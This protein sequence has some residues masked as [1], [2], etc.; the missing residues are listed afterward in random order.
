MDVPLLGLPAS[1]WMCFWHPSACVGRTSTSPTWSS[2]ARPDNRD[3]LPGEMQACQP[4]LDSQLEMISPKVVVTLGKY[5]F[6]KFFP[7]E[8]HW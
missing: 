3:P 8:S 4:Y 2:V 5:A 7:A 1:F 6:S